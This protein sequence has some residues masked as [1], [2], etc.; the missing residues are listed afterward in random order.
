MAGDQ[1]FPNE[2]PAELLREMMK[3]VALLGDEEG[4]QSLA[5]VQEETAK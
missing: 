3:G 4:Y 5:E 1:S 2:H